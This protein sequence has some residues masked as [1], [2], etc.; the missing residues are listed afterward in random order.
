MDVFEL[1][2]SRRSIRKFTDKPVF[3]D[4][5]HKIIE[6]GRWAPSGMNNQP[7]KF[8]IIKDKDIKTRISKLTHY[9]KIVQSADT[10]ISV[11]LDRVESYDRTKDIM[12]I[13]ACIQNMLLYIHSEGLGAVWLGQIL[14]NKEKVLEL[15]GG[16]KD[17][18]LMAVIALGYPAEKGGKPGRK[19]HKETVFFRK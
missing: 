8:A 13:G 17:L 18:E 6:A 4:M 11:F 14:A 1:I 2:K 10:L 15:A 5:I 19:G 12:A 9:S 16:S 7:W 3:D